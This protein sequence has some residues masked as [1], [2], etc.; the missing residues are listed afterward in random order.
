M[1]VGGKLFA[2][3]PE[4]SASSTGFELDQATHRSCL[5]Q[6][7]KNV[8]VTK[9][10]QLVCEVNLQSISDLLNKKWVSSAAM[11]MSTLQITSYL[12][13]RF[14]T[15]A[16]N[17]HIVNVHEHASLGYDRHRAEVIFSTCAK[18][19]EALCSNWGDKIIGMSSDGEKK[20]ASRVCGMDTHF[21]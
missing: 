13:V 7:L 18:L 1:D 12:D 5:D 2:L 10:A 11:D 16:P 21:Q 6:V 17:T 19:C 15:F 14:R 3:Q 8:T 20:M 9:Y 4:L